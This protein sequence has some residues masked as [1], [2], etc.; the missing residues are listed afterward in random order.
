MQRY[1][2]RDICRILEVKRHIIRY[3]E[4]EIPFLIPRKDLYRNRVYT[5]HDL[6]LLFR[7][8]YL[9][10]RKKFSLSRAS[11]ELWKE[12]TS[13]KQDLRLKIHDIRVDLLILYEQAG[14]QKE[15]LKNFFDDSTK[16][17]DIK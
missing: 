12:I 4:Q 17:D 3:W 5:F 16:S 9:I 13:E 11:E 15:L 6:S 2:I 14:K 8:K 1:Y 10:Y 7:L